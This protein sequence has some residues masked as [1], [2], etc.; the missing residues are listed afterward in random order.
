MI[1]HS[2]FIPNK[3]LTDLSS[4]LQVNFQYFEKTDIYVDLIPLNFLIITYR[5]LSFI[6]WVV[7]VTIFPLKYPRKAKKCH[8]RVFW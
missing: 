5:F 3:E 1:K 2:N 8:F 7:L 6:F 4:V